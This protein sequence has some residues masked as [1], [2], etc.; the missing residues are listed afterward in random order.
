[1]LPGLIILQQSLDRKTIPQ[2]LY[3]RG[4]SRRD[5]GRNAELQDK[6]SSLG[7]CD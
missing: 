1:M 3:E 2:D 4:D 5:P 7:K 6:I